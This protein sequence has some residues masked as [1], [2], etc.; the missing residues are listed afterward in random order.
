MNNDNDNYNN[1]SNNNKVWES[2]LR[3]GDRGQAMEAEPL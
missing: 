3:R 1:N 2:I